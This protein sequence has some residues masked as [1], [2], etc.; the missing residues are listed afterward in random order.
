MGIVGEPAVVE[1]ARLTARYPPGLLRR[2]FSHRVPPGPPVVGRPRGQG[3][4]DEG[5]AEPDVRPRAAGPGTRCPASSSPASNGS[6]S[7]SDRMRRDI[8]PAAVTSSTSASRWSTTSRPRHGPRRCWSTTRA[9]ATVRQLGDALTELE[10]NGHFFG[11]CSL[12]LVLHGRTARSARPGRRSDEGARGP[13]RE[14]FEE[15]YNL[16]NAWLSIVPGNGA[17]NVRR[18]ALLETN[19]R[20]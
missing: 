17:H 20:T 14:H 10:V 5:A 11:A 4:V 7:A 13:R 8:Q 1:A 15:T 2:R 19:S 6:A 18:L 3:A 9:S 16:L 12:T